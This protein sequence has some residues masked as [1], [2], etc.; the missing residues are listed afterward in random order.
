MHEK[1][2]TQYCVNDIAVSTRSQTRT[3][4]HIHDFLVHVDGEE[5]VFTS[6]E[7]DLI[8]PVVPPILNRSRTS[9]IPELDHLVDGFPPV[10]TNPFGLIAGE[11]GVAFDR[12]DLEVAVVWRSHP[13]ISIHFGSLTNRYQLTKVASSYA[14]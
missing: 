12:S 10:L 5:G 13:V 4:G 11:V 6:A 9:Y 2:T 3:D 7:R 1:L 8:G 14:N